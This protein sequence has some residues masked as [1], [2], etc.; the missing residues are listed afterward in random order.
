MLD[1]RTSTREGE[2]LTQGQLERQ[3][4]PNQ[5]KVDVEMCCGEKLERKGGNSEGHGNLGRGAWDC[6][7]R[8]RGAMAGSVQ[9]LSRWRS[10]GF[11]A[12]GWR[13]KMLETG[14]VCE[15]PG[16]C[17]KQVWGAEGGQEMNSLWTCLPSCAS[18]PSP[19]KS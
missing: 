12:G 9:G 10:A 4:S 15:A 14:T 7:L 6:A 8:Q 2:T 5:E 3:S 19:E 17:G 18:L 16:Y 13:E 1:A 11:C